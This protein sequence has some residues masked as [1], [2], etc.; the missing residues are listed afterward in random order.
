MTDDEDDSY[1]RYDADD[2][3]KYVHENVNLDNPSEVAWYVQTVGCEE[4][5][6][7]FHT[8]QE[9]EACRDMWC[10]YW[11]GYYQ[12]EHGCTESEAKDRPVDTRVYSVRVECSAEELAEEV[13]VEKKRWFG[14]RPFC[15]I[16]ELEQLLNVLLRRSALVRLDEH[17]SRL[18]CCRRAMRKVSRNTNGRLSIQRIDANCVFNLAPLRIGV[19][20]LYR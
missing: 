20:V 13:E 1:D 15:R 17:R 2:R 19:E 7:I 11:V 10:K 14:K 6:M 4:Q 5:E 12:T 9:A 16:Q 3:V 18:M 8:K